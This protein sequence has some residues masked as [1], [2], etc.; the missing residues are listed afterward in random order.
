MKISVIGCGYLG[1]VH[2]ASMAEL[3]HDVIGIDTHEPTVQLVNSGRAPVEEPGL[4]DLIAAHGHNLH[5]T[6]ELAAAAS[7]DLSVLLVPTPSD[8]SGAFSNEHV[9]AATEEAGHG[10][11]AGTGAAS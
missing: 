9:L 8:E 2:A 5:A 4:Q 3:G 11:G 7:A 10:T 6:T 1:A